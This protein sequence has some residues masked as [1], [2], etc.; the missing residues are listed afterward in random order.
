MEHVHPFFTY[1]HISHK[2]NKKPFD[3]AKLDSRSI[4]NIPSITIMIADIVSKV[5]IQFSKTK[6]KNQKPSPPRF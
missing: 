1:S 5:D 2:Y 6:I 3:T 4:N